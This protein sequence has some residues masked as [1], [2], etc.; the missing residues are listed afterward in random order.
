MDTIQSEKKRI[1]KREQTAQA[2]FFLL[3]LTAF[4]IPAILL[5]F[6]ARSP[7]ALIQV[8]FNT[9]WLPLAC[10]FLFF[11]IFLLGISRLGPYMQETQRQKRHW[12][13]EYG[14]HIQAQ[15]TKR[16]GENALVIGGRAR[17]RGASYIVY[18]NWQ[19][20]QTGQLYAF[21]V[22]TRFSPALR[23]LPEGTFCPVQLDRS[24]P[25]FCV[26]PDV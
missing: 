14:L 17:G 9:C 11:L 10:F 22:S 23:S 18:L 7:V 8:L 25:T 20:P 5:V 24:D 1:Q 26:V 21:R 4:L 6:L 15:L 3:G 16:P 12:L 2:A 13:N 19:D